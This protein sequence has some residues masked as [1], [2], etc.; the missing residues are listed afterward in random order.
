MSL[1]LSRDVTISGFLW[2]PEK[3]EVIASSVLI[4]KGRSLRAEIQWVA[5]QNRTLAS[6][7]QEDVSSEPQTEVPRQLTFVAPGGVVTLVEC[8]FAS[9]R[10]NLTY[11]TSVGT[12]DVRFAIPGSAGR[13]D[14]TKVHSMTS[15]VP[16]LYAWLNRPGLVARVSNEDQRVSLHTL[17]PESI[18]V[19]QFNLVLRPFGNISPLNS[20]RN[21]VTSDVEV[22]TT[23]DEARAWDEHIEAHKAIADLMTLS[24]WR[25]APPTLRNLRH[26]DDV[27]H[28]IENSHRYTRPIIV[29]E[30]VALG[31][32]PS[33]K[34]DHL[35]RF[36]EIG[37]NGL[38][39]WLELRQQHIRT[40]GPALSPVYIGDQSVE[41]T[42]VQTAIGIE[43]L[44]YS[45]L[46]T[47]GKSEVKAAQAN[48]KSRLERIIADVKEVY[49]PTIAIPAWTQQ[50]ANTYNGIKH[51][52]RR[53]PPY[54]D[55]INDRNRMALLLRTWYALRL[56]S[57][58]SSLKERVTTDQLNQE[59][60]E[61]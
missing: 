46:V 50:A 36:D 18:D 33:E 42:L 27:A 53:L 60:V 61:A 43:A 8:T 41:S 58:P 34:V 4:R 45:I 29:P 9:Y 21:P 57:E 13:V 54:L 7:F 14:Y 38:R 37:E 52:N 5:R 15:S 22:T 25:A 2:D 31:E 39:T 56:G 49:D 19:S 48:F 12:L 11:G 1:D 51:A 6:W 16:H 32:S 23:F 28:S 59:W 44:G 35:I 24:C 3:Q 30:I 17:S 10:S 20:F 26:D 47:E 40:I 55:S